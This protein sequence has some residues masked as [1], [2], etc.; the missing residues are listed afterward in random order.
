[1]PLKFG[2]FNVLFLYKPQGCDTLLPPPGVK[3]LSQIFR[4]NRSRSLVLEEKPQ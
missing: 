3:G 2:D 1:M 4:L